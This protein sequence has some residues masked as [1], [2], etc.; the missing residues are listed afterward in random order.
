[1]NSLQKG[2]CEHS[3]PLLFLETNT[4]TNVLGHR[5]IASNP[6]RTIKSTLRVTNR[7]ELDSSPNASHP[8]PLYI[9]F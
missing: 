2:V 6:R 1:M 4:S 8:D 3:A 7:K 9:M 5:S